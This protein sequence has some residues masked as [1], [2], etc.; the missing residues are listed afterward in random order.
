MIATY[1]PGVPGRMLNVRTEPS[2]LAPVAR[3][4]PK[5]SEECRGVERG[6]CLLEGGYA[7]ARFLTVTDGHARGGTAGSVADGARDE[8]KAPTT[9][10]MANP[11]DKPEGA[12]APPVDE[13]R[14]PLEAM[15][16]SE[17]RKLADGSG[18]RVPKGARKAEILDLLLSDDE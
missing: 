12:Q 5:G 18:V 17:L 15:T 7:D 3:R 14:A 1:R 13:G 16:I 2:A 9:G 4:M 6:W 10:E 8:Q 11:D